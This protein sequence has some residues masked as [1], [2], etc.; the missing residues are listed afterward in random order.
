MASITGSAGNNRLIGSHQADTILAGEG[1]DRIS[2]RGGDDTID[3]EGGHD[4]IV[5]GGSGTIVSPAATA[6]TSSWAERTTTPWTVEPGMT[7]SGE[8]VET[9]FLTGAA[10]ADIFTFD[11]GDGTDIVTDF[12]TAEDQIDLSSFATLDSF[13]DLMMSQSGN[14]VVIDLTEQGGGQIT[15]QNVVL[16]DLTADSFSFREG[17]EITPTEGS[18]WMYGEAG[19][20]T[21]TGNEGTNRM[22]GRDG[23]DTLDGGGGDDWYYGGEGDDTFVISTNGGND[24]IVDMKDGEDLIDLRAFTGISG[25]DDLSISQTSGGTSVID[26]TEHGGGTVNIYATGDN[27][28]FDELDASNFIFYDDGA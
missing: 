18:T 15:L 9:T 24:T 26:L 25:F 4:D 13:A 20:D 21:L 11:R 12:D 27:I 1:N 17:L 28:D 5:I 3:G 14:D 8:V 2:G 23:D 7:C 19:N 10:G 6:T 22:L 16:A